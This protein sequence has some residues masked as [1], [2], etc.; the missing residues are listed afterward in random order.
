LVS[1][2][3]AKAFSAALCRALSEAWNYQAISQRARRVTWEQTT[4]EII[5][6]FERVVKPVVPD[7]V[8]PEAI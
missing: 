5:A 4:R 2:W 8:R 7:E 6:E 1:F 3:D